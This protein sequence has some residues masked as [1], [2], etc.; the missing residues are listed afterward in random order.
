MIVCSHE[1]NLK[2]FTVIFEDDDQRL[3]KEL[4]ERYGFGPMNLEAGLARTIGNGLYNPRFKAIIRLVVKMLRH[5]FGVTQLQES[6]RQTLELICQ[7]LE[8]VEEDLDEL[9]KGD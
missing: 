2:Q 4:T 6:N 8:V 7:I 5:D 3:W 1:D 9:L